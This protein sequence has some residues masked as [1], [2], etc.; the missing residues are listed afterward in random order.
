MT[1]HPNRSQIRQVAGVYFDERGYQDG[2]GVLTVKAREDGQL[3]HDV[4]GH[5]MPLTISTQEGRTAWSGDDLGVGW[6][7]P[8]EPQ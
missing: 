3:L 1:N 8:D 5:W 6:F 4:D 7:E 2:R